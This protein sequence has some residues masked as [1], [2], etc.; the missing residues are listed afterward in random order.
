MLRALQQP[1]VQA[2]V[3]ERYGLEVRIKGD[4]AIEKIRR[5]ELGRRQY[6]PG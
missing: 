4:G 5:V 1:A 2:N 6:D 3:Y